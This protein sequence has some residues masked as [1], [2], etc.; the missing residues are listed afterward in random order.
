MFHT[1]GVP[2][3]Y[4]EI[5]IGEPDIKR[6]GEDITILSIGATLYPVMKAADILKEKYGLS[7]RGY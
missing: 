7:C 1:G 4:Y 6:T 2:E 3:G 5:P